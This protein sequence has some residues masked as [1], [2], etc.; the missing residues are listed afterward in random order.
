M[1]TWNKMKISDIAEVIGGGT[2][3]TGDSTYWGEEIPWLTPK[4]LSGY[5]K[6]YISKGSRSLSKVGLKN[7]SAKILP[8]GSILLTSRAPIGYLAIAEDNLCTNQGFK[9]LV[10]KEEY[11]SKFIYYLLKKNIDYIINMSSGST[12]AEISG[13]Q[14]K[15][16]EFDIP[17]LETQ[18]KIAKVLS[19]IDDKIELNNSIN[20]NL[21]QQAQAIF[22]SWFVD[23]EP[24]GGTMP[25]DW[26]IGK[27][28]DIVEFLNGYAFKSS[29]LLNSQDVD[30]YDV[31]KQG[32]I[33]RGG[34]FNPSG[35]KSWYPKDKAKNLEK[36]I[37]KKGDVLMAM[38]DMKDNVAILGNTALMGVD[39][40]Y[41]VNQRVGLLRA[42]NDYNISYPFIYILTNSTDFLMD[43][44]K[45]ANSG[46]Q[47]NLSSAE[48][49]NSDVVIATK[50]INSKFDNIVK[51]FFEQIFNNN[52]ENSRLI[53]L[54]DTLLPKLMSGEI[55]VSNVDIST[56]K[57]LFSEDK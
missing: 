1:T 25:L 3:S 17:D 44:R 27:L 34:G 2:P 57:L 5:K 21:E 55:D 19:A 12:F 4:D 54:R 48:I 39:N 24:F 51:P 56:D 14:V 30:C 45:R 46:V 42:Q 22:K 36:Y 53:Q 8:K 52:L 13:G 31:F 32:H 49:K 15:N 23:F 47:V 9:S 18:Q 10:L 26:N 41:I 43:L 11:D 28:E 40:K 6:R 29:E 35:T 7:C 20:N 16:L 37:L 33:N 38:T 50:D